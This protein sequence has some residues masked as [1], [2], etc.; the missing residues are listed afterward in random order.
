MVAVLRL[1]STNAPLIMMSACSVPAWSQSSSV[2]RQSVCV[3]QARERTCKRPERQELTIDLVASLLLLH[4][5]KMQLHRRAADPRD[6][7]EDAA[8]KQPSNRLAG[9]LVV[10]VRGMAEQRDV[11][12]SQE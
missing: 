12:S 9:T 11:A 8:A 2:H 7:H 1:D 10:L 5:L 6:E 3:A 4:S